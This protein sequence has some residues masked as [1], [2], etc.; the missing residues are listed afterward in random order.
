MPSKQLATLIN[1]FKGNDELSYRM[2]SGKHGVSP[3]YVQKIINQ[4]TKIVKRKKSRYRFAIRVRKLQPEHVVYLIE[5]SQIMS[6]FKTSHTLLFRIH[7]DKC[8]N[9]VKYFAK[10]KFEQKIMVT[11]WFEQK[12]TFWFAGFAFKWETKAKKRAAVR[13]RRKIKIP[14][15]KLMKRGSSESKCSASHSF[16]YFSKL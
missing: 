11:F 5:N 10:Q 13:A 1:Q 14:D 4:K 15:V 7:V 12:T 8:Q 9:T 6:G 16:E 3:S 2:A